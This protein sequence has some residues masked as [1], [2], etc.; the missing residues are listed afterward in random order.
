[1]KDL[2]LFCFN[3]VIFFRASANVINIVNYAAT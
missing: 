3:V 1:M 2:M